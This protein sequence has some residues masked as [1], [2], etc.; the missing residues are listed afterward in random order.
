LFHA[1][2]ESVVDTTYFGM[3]LNLSAK[4]TSSVRSGHASAK[5]S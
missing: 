3:P 5:P 4:P 1:G 2:S